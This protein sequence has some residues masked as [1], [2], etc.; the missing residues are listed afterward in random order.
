MPQTH[1]THFYLVATRRPLKQTDFGAYNYA[2]HIYPVYT[3]Y[4][5]AYGQVSRF[6]PRQTAR[7]N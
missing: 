1:T 4:P 5:V 6:E 3:V 2:L 7:H